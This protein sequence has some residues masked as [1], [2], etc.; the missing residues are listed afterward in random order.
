MNEAARGSAQQTAEQEVNSS[1]RPLT[2]GKVVALLRPEFPDLSI[3]KV[4]YLEDRGLLSP[5][6]S[7]GGYRKY[8]LEDV[9][10]LRTVLKLQRDEYLPLEV[11]KQRLDRATA[12]TPGQPVARGTLS[13]RSPESLKRE[14]PVYS[15]EEVTGQSGCTQAFLRTLIEYRLVQPSQAMGEGGTQFTESDVEIARICSSLARFGVEPRNLRLLASCAEREGALVLQLV[16]PF[17]RSAHKDRREYGE[18]LLKDLAALYAELMRLLF[19]KE[20]QQAL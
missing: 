8:S 12:L 19:F 9:R 16:A 14:E 7:P 3:T 11:I 6:R 15:W 17:L 18:E 5:E 20:L 2:I 13:L 4:R 1:E 10:L